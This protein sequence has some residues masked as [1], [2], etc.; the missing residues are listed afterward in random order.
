MASTQE[1]RNR[2]VNTKHF[3]SGHHD[4]RPYVLDYFIRLGNRSP[5]S[6]LETKNFLWAILSLSCQEKNRQ[7]QVGYDFN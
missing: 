5:P 4:S 6:E 3:P 7:N 2:R 1:I